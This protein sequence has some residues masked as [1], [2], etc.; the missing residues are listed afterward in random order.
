MIWSKRS[1]L[2]LAVL[3]FLSSVYSW[4]EVCLTDAEWEELDSILTTLA[5]ASTELETQLTR[6]QAL[7]TT[8]RESLAISRQET[9]SAKLSL[10]EAV[11]SWQRQRL[12]TGIVAGSA[13]VVFGVVVA[14]L[15]EY[16]IHSINQ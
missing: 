16:I 6:V 4:G 7:L 1:F 12:E 8:A 11:K 13:G 14:L 10:S 3:L 2:L 15:I 9:V 5:T